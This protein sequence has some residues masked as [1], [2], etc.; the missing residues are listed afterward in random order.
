MK[1]TFIVA[2]ALL[3]WVALPA[4][5]NRP[6]GL[7]KENIEKFKDSAKERI[8][9]EHIA[10]LTAELEL[11]PE[12]A[13]AFWPVYNQAADKQR[14]QHCEVSAAKKALKAAVKEG[15]MGMVDKYRGNF[16][17]CVEK[18]VKE[19]LKDVL[20]QPTGE[21]PLCVAWKRSDPFELEGTAILITDMV[22]DII[23][24]P[25]Q[26][27]T[28][29][30]P[31]EALNIY[32]KKLLPDAFVLGIDEVQD[33]RIATNESPV[34]Y[35]RMVSYENDHIS[36]ALTWINCVMEIHLIAPSPDRRIKHT[37]TVATAL[38]LDGEIA[39]TDGAPLRFTGIQARNAR[40]YLVAGQITVSAQYILSRIKEDA[41]MIDNIVVKGR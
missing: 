13:Q 34:I 12:E 1:K 26:I 2:L 25:D 35:V 28:D 36:M 9:S 24:Y 16:E 31:V 29:P 33:T 17:K 15:K 19:C 32:L 6:Q 7:T 18:Y 39:L 20:M 14:A 22:F 40:D 30:D 41:P 23:E 10:Y 4:Q 27:T 37:R 3:V 38:N 11:S 5:N 8:R 21:A